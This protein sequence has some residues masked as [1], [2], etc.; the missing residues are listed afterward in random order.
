MKLTE[1]RYRELCD[2]YSGVCK[3]CEEIADN[4]EPDACNYTCE[5]C[6][7]DSVFGIEEA[8]M[9]GFIEII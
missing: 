3:D 8:F 7:E 4:V 2:E 9:D 6:G 5:N 1:E